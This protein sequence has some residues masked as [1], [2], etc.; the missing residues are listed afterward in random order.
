[1]TPRRLFDGEKLCAQITV[2]LASGSPGGADQGRLQP[3]SP[4]TDARGPALTG[5]FVEAGAQ[6]GPRDEMGRRGT[7]RPVGA[8]LGDEHPGRRVAQAG[9]RR[10]EADGGANGTE[11][12]SHAR[13]YVVHDGAEGVDLRGMQLDREAMMGG[14]RPCRASTSS[15]RVALSRPRVRSANRSGSVSPATRRDSKSYAI[16][17]S[18]PG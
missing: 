15:A 9:H 13:I 12:V 4:L 2:L 3:G 16:R 10:Q 11:G 18:T 7:S 6:A 5:T 8:D 1:M 17:L 14:T